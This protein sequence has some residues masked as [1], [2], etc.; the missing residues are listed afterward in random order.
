[1]LPAPPVTGSCQVP[2][3]DWGNS[4]M[5]GGGVGVGVG[6]AAAGGVGDGVG[7]ALGDEGA[8]VSAGPLDAVDVGD[9]L[10]GLLDGWTEEVGGELAGT[11]GFWQAT[12]RSRP[13]TS[14]AATVFVN[15]S[16]PGSG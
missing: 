1:M 4:L 15:A 10:V 14:M 2:V 3:Q 11:T 8:V 16:S 6:V 7:G 12:R 13:V 5:G 9:G